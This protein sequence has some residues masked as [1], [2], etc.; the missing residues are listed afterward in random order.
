MTL[1]HPLQPT[2]VDSSTRAPAGPS[3]TA[4]ETADPVS[5]FLGTQTPDRSARLTEADVPS[6]ESGLQRLAKCGSWR[7][8]SSLSQRL[9][10]TAHPVDE[11]L[12]L[13][14]DASPAS[15]HSQRANPATRTA[16]VVSHHRAAQ[17][18]Q[19]R[20]GTWLTRWTTGKLR[21]GLSRCDPGGDRLS[22]R[23]AFWAT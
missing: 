12:R 13:R 16:Q 1:G 15:L 22:E 4:A 23:W 7:S 19:L 3:A 14:C 5:R 17:A 18:S 2:T 8:V 20:T 9:L 6:N 21:V 11:L 10:S